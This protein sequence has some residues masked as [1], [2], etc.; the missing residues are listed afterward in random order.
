MKLQMKLRKLSIAGKFLAAGAPDAELLIYGDIGE[1]WYGQSVSAND[2][3][4]QLQELQAQ[5]LRVRVNSFGGSVTDG[6]AIYNAIRSLGISIVTRIEGIAASIASLIAVVGDQVEMFANAIFMVHAPWTG[7]MGNSTDLRE[8]A[9]VLDTFATAM[10]TSYARKSGKPASDEL[11]Q[12]TDGVDHWYTAAEAKAA[13]YVDTVL[14]DDAPDAE[15]AAARADPVLAAMSRY[16]SMPQAIKAS[17]HPHFSAALSRAGKKPKA[18]SAA[19][20]AQESR[21]WKALALS[22]GITI[23]DG[24]DEAAIKALILQKLALAA[25]ATDEAITAA[26]ARRQNPPQGPPGPGSTVEPSAAAVRQTAIED[27][28]VVAARSRPNDPV[29]GGMR[30]RLVL[31]TS[32]TVDQAR[33]ALLAHMTSDSVPFAGHTSVVA[34]ADA[35]DKRREAM[36]AALLARVNRASD[37]QRASLGANPYRGLRLLDMASDALA[38]NG[39]AVRGMQR[40]D[41]AEYAL[42]RRD[43]RISAAMTTSDFPVVLENTL[44]QIMLNGYA[45][46]PQ[47]WQQFCKV[48]DVSDFRDWN[49]LVP[50]FLGSLDDVNEAGEYKNKS[51]PDATKNQVR[52][53]RTGNIIE[54]TPETIINDDIGYI[55]Q[56]A[57]SGGQ[58][59]QRTIEGRVYKLLNANPVVAS[60]GHALFSVEHGNL[61][62]QGTGTAPT[63]AA[64]NGM[65]VAMGSQKLPGTTDDFMDAKPALALTSLQTEGPL[66]QIIQSPYDPDAASKLQRPNIVYNAVEDIIG[67]PRI[68]TPTAWYFFADPN[69]APVLVVAFLDGQRAPVL[70]QDENFRTGGL[71]WR[72]ELP[73]GVGVADYRGGA[74]NYGA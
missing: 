47:T 21:M 12:L 64:V 18:A 8:T 48:M 28:F 44:H 11:L 49:L 68:S 4:Q 63:M 14:D 15:E 27:L 54:I 40:G 61:V 55:L 26:V 20:P 67:S 6:I 41:I 34:G 37:A 3:V 58:A 39:F 70:K 16:R 23:P 24:A 72:I 30:D 33:A 22:M 10:S 62:A 29:L 31:D 1:S 43:H 45:M 65:L 36:T 57:E 35:I 51:I 17:A 74:M 42:G 13:G 9:D 60:T 38:A 56:V 69:V 5:K 25:D 52:A 73:F 59:G 53:K 7:V 32:Q 19:S 71:K 2:I 66:R 46:A 50:G